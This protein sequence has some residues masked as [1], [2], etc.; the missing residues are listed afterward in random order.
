ME[1]LMWFQIEIIYP[2]SGSFDGEELTEVQKIQL[3]N[4]GLLLEDYETD[5][6]IFNLI[7]DPISQINPKAFIP[8]NKTNKK[9]YSEIVFESGNIVMA[10]GK[11][12]NVYTKLNEYLNTLPSVTQE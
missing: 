3:K 8:R 5:I 1:D 7:S 12:I 9:Y 10:L 4:E 6:G 2:I 11:P